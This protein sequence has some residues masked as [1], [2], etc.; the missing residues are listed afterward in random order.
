MNRGRQGEVE[1]S[2]VAVVGGTGTLGSRVVTELLRRGIPVRALSRTSTVVP[3]GA[4]HRRVDLTTGE[5]LAEA[6]AGTTVVIDT[7]NSTKAAQETLVAGTRRLL[8]AAA[9]AGVVHHLAISIVGID[10]VPISYYRAKL[11]Q[12]EEIEGGPLPW[13]ILRA[14]QFHQLLGDGFAAAARFGIRPTGPARLQP[15]EPGIVAAHLVA[16]ALAAPAGRLPDL[17]GPRVQTLGELSATW[18]SA[19]GARRF[20]LRVPAWGKIG[21][22]LADGALC[23]P[24]GAAAGAD[25]EEW[26]RHE[27]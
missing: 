7:A 2:T 17:A 8:E 14:T 25:F 5:G 12:E 13:T 11:A 19:R 3:T 27:R 4:E 23:A 18:A 1:R 16:T 22:A 6:L 26:L 21:K 9:A 10:R 20:P 15:I 24:E